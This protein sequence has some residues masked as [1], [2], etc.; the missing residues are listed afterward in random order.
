MAIELNY[1]NKDELPEA[2]KADAVFKEIFTESADGAITVNVNG[3]KTQSDVDTVREALRKEREDH[4]STKEKLKPWGDLS[5]QDTLTKLDKIKE[6]E[7][8]AEGKLDDEKINQLVEG[9]LGQATGPLQRQIEELNKNLTIS[10]DENEILKLA[11][12][13]RDRNEG[14]RKHASESKVHSTAIPDIEMSAANMFEKNSEGRWVTKNDLDVTAGLD[15]KGWLREMQTKRPH[16]W[17][18]NEGGKAKGAN[19]NTGPG[20]NPFSKE[21]WNLTEQGK[22][23]KEQG[24]DI[25]ARMAQTAGTTVGGQRPN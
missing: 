25:A 23:I 6:L 8:L 12:D 19:G 5:P 17:P 2:L 21:G 20:G 9:R 13:T 3:M 4:V 7:I 1:K 24:I 11:V 22:I 10:K 18:E 15:F 16:W 14:I